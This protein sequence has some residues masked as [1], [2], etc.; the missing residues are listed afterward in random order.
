MRVTLGL[1]L[2]GCLWLA[3]AA[4]AGVPAVADP[5]DIAGC[6][7]TDYVGTQ[8]D[9]PNGL[10]AGILDCPGLCRLAEAEC[11]KLTKLSFSCQ[12]LILG[13][14]ATWA[15]SN[16]I[17]TIPADP[18]ALKECKLAAQ[19]QASSDKQGVKSAQQAALSACSQWSSTC[20][21]TCD[22]P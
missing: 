12:N 6:G 17:E 16:C 21:N 7:E 13:K 4:R 18:A 14:R 20:Q 1:F 2:C 3:A 15:R 8:M 10:Y 19:S 5:F 22:A 11:K 9:D